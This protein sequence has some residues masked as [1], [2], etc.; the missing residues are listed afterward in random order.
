M[1]EN[2]TISVSFSEVEEAHISNYF[3]L[4]EMSGEFLIIQR[5]DNTFYFLCTNNCDIVSI[6]QSF[7]WY[8]VSKDTFNDHLIIGIGLS[9]KESINGELYRVQDETTLTLWR[10]ILHTLLSRAI[11]CASSS[12]TIPISKAR[13]VSTGPCVSISTIITRPDARTYRY[14]TERRAIWYLDLKKDDKQPLSPRSS[15]F[16]S[17][18]CRSLRRKPPT[19]C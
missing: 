7:D 4:S 10:D 5:S 15:R 2:L 16:V 11:S 19:P 8:I 17:P 6:C 1:I 14:L 3:R 13:C 12:H 9:D 18:G